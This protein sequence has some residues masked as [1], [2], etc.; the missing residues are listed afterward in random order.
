LK[1]HDSK[2][3]LTRPKNKVICVMISKVIAWCYFR[4]FFLFLRFNE[5]IIVL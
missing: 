2:L 4:K 1:I 3:S 5:K